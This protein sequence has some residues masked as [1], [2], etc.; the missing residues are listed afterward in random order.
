VALALLLVS[1]LGSYRAS[2]GAKRGDRP[3]MIF[4]ALFNLAFGTSALVV[5][6]FAW[7]SLN[8][9]WGS[10]IHG[11]VVWTILGLHT[12]DAF[13]DLFF[14]LVLVILLLI[15]HSGPKVRLAVHVDS[16]VWY[17]VVLIWIPLYVVIYWGG[18]LVGTR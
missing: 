1:C 13:A 16:V 2:Q 18:R 8:F 4:W 17:F 11:S 6:G 14:T 9:T 5:R 3:A 7:A 12:L 15:G 10:D